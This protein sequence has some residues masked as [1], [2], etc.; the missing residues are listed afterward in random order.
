MYVCMIMMIILTIMFDIYIYVYIYI[1]THTLSSSRKPSGRFLMDS[2]VDIIQRLFM[3]SVVAG[4]VLL[5]FPSLVCLW[6]PSWQ[7]NVVYGFRR[8]I[9]DGFCRR[10]RIHNFRTYRVIPR[11]FV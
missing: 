2:V 11:V 9:F 3:V 4:N 1:Y 8:Q 5:W 10:R 6:F 7:E